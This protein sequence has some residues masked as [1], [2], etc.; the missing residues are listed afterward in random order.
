MYPL[1]SVLA[2]WQGIKLI[3]G[4]EDE[5]YIR[6]IGMLGR[7]KG[8]VDEKTMGIRRDERNKGKK[9]RDVGQWQQE[10]VALGEPS[11]FVA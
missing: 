9:M 6:G 2:H 5:K 8:S 4:E 10:A 11:A 3:A 7:G 1:T